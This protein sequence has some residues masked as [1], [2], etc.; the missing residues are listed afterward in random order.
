MNAENRG[1]DGWRAGEDVAPAGRTNSARVRRLLCRTAPMTGQL[2]PRACVVDIETA[3]SGRRSAPAYRA[4]AA[5]RVAPAG[6]P[7]ETFVAYRCCVVDRGRPSTHRRPGSAS[8]V[9]A[10][11][12]LS[13][14]R[15]DPD[16][17]PSY[18]AGDRLRLSMPER[19]RATG[20]ARVGV[21]G[22]ASER[23]AVG[24][25]AARCAGDTK[26]SRREYRQ[27]SARLSRGKSQGARYERDRR[28]G[29]ERPLP[30]AD[31]GCVRMRRLS[32][33]RK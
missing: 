6:R 32:R 29:S 22:A 33:H 4:M 3:V 15:R 16:T 26:M 24:I 28:M 31:R 8:D 23:P 5:A 21:S 12:I 30:V 18:P 10:H 11:R 1:A 13:D 20:R 17:Q 25:A 9:S 27:T 19:E 14:D 2:R 7:E